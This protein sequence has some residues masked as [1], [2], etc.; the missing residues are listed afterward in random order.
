MRW[1]YSGS[2]RPEFKVL[3]C[4]AFRAKL[5]RSA[6]KEWLLVT[7]STSGQHLAAVQKPWE[8]T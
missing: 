7:I 5:L 1:A 4:Q 6:I 8:R 3:A 2:M